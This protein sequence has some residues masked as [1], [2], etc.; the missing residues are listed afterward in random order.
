[1]ATTRDIVRV[2]SGEYPE[3]EKRE[4]EIALLKS[5]Y[6]YGP[7]NPYAGMHFRSLQKKHPGVADAHFAKS[8]RAPS[9]P[10]SPEE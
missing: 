8:T 10:P 7:T 5:Y 9:T 2:M 1:M 4:R 6:R 3:K